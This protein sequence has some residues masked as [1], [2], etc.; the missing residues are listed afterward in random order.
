[1]PCPVPVKQEEEEEEEQNDLGAAHLAL[2][3]LGGAVPSASMSTYE[4]Q[5]LDNIAR[6]EAMLSTKGRILRNLVSKT[7]EINIAY[8]V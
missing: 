5:R 7:Q 1:M 8:S 4:Q 2:A 6:N 3:G